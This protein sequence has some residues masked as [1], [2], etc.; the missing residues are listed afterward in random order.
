MEGTVIKLG[1]QVFEHSKEQDLTRGICFLYIL[2]V[3]KSLT[4]KA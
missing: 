3:R 1:D 2:F 4:A